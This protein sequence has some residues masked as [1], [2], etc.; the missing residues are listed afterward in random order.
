MFPSA[1]TPCTV[2]NLR[3]GWRYGHP[4]G[5]GL[6]PR[7][8]L[9][10]PQD[11]AAA[12]PDRGS[13][14]SSCGRTR[15]ACLRYATPGTS[16]RAGLAAAAAEAGVSERIVMAQTRTRSLTMVRRYIREGSL[17]RENAAAK[18]GL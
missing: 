17:F 18:V 4:G 11:A 8:P 15:P 5:A 16:L 9:G 6:P 13:V 10:V 7:R 1:L 12:G 2:R 3:H 14:W